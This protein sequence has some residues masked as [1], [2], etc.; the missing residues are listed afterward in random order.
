MKKISKLLSLFLV[1]C[2][3]TGC[4]AKDSMEDITIY[5]SIYP[6]EYVTRVLYGDYANVI[7]IYP[8]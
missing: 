1:L 7:S 6:I 2:I 3:I 4:K 5:T 8:N